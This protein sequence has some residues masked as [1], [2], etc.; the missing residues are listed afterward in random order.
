M[1]GTTGLGGETTKK[2]EIID[3]QQRQYALQRYISDSFPLLSPEDR[4]LKLPL[5]LRGESAPWADKRS[6]D[7]DQELQTVLVETNLPIN[8]VTEVHNTDEVRDLFIRLQSGTTLTR[9]QIRDAWPGALGPRIEQWAGKF[10]KSPKFKFF[11]AVDRRG[12]RDDDEAANDKRVNHRATCAQLCALLLGT[13]S[14]PYATPSIN[15]NDL[16]AL[17]HEYTQANGH[18]DPLNQIEMVFADIE[19]V[20]STAEIMAQFFSGRK[21]LPK[22]TLFAM[23]LFLQ[24]AHRSDKFKL[25]SESSLKLAEYSRDPLVT[26]NGRTTSGPAIKRYYEEWRRSLP[27]GVAEPLNHKRAFDEKQKQEIHQGQSGKCAVCNESVSDG[28]EE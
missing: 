7:L 1:K 2:Y 4:R 25:T 23:A 17:Y 11:D 14:N 3:G 16:D 6:S 20:V 9:Q 13:A 28:D 22:M 15:A 8:L 27:E 12:T 21:K 5:S 19:K 26:Q 10:D 24:D 18:N